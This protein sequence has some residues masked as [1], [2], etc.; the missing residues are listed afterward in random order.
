MLKITN[1]DFNTLIVCSFRYALG[2][3]TYMPSLICDIITD[4]VIEL[5]Q[6]TIELIIK[7]IKKA[8]ET[9][10][11][12]MDMDKDSWLILLNTLESVKLRS[13]LLIGMEP[14]C[15]PAVV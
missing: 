12:G 15:K 1:N 11:Y 10:N 3:M 5:E 2:R 14:G 7:E 13:G 6:H 8:V 4:N 9:N